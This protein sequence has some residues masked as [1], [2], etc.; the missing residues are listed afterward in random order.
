M[1]IK[2]DKNKKR[3]QRAK[4]ASDIH[5]TK[6]RPRLTVNRSLSQIYAQV[7]NDDDSTTL[8]AVNTLQE[9]VKKAIK[10]KTKSEAAFIV[11]GLIAKAALAKKI[12]KV[13]FDRSGYVYTGRI[14]KVAEGAR[15]GG[16]EF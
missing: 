7:I 1:I 8:V 5:G 13:V 3:L 15:K 11:G 2:E 16:L 9:D 4:R 6:E 12:K 14:A 10:G